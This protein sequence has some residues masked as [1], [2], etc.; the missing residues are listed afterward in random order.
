MCGLTANS[1][2][3]MLA[4]SSAAPLTYRYVSHDR[5]LAVLPFPGALRQAA[6]VSNVHW[7]SMMVRVET[8]VL[9]MRELRR[10]QDGWQETG[11]EQGASRTGTV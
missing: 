6:V 2:Q 11:G 1:T 9:N 7:L 4:F 3:R 10:D 5:E 8:S